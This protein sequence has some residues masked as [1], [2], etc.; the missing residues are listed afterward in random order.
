LSEEGRCQPVKRLVTKKF[1]GDS[2]SAGLFE[3]ALARAFAARDLDAPRGTTDAISGSGAR[4]GCRRIE[5]QFGF[6]DHVNPAVGADQHGEL[7]IFAAA[8]RFGNIKDMLRIQE[9]R[10]HLIHISAGLRSL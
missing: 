3:P 10:V 6:H 1:G 9:E 4:G 2:G 5:R 7:R 8:V